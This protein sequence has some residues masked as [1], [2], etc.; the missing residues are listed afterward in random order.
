MHGVVRATK[1]LDIVPEP[2]R[3]NTARLA[4]A[5][6][7]L[8]AEVDLGDMKTDELGIEPDEEGLAAGGNWVLQTKHGRLD[9]MQDVPGL[10]SWQQ[11]REGAVERDGVLYAGYAELVSMKSSAGRNEDLADIAK[12]RAARG[13][14]QS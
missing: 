9:V 3:A 4:A 14:A 10:R 1:D 6:R 5:L 11:L 2:S 13:E 7:E 8:R 12:L